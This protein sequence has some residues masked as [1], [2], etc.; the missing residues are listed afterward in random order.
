V[1]KL[2]SLTSDGI[3]SGLKLDVN[4]VGVS[5]VVTFKE[6]G[7]VGIGT[8]SPTSMF[9]VGSS[10][11]FQ[12]NSTGNIVSLNG[13][14]TSFPSTNASGALVNNGS[15]AF[16][17]SAIPSVG[18]W[19]AL[20]YPTWSSGTPFVKMTAAGTFSLDANT[21]ATG[22]GT[23][24]GTNTGDQTSV[25]GNAGTVTGLSVVSGKT[26]TVDNSLTIQGTDST[27]LSLAAALTVNTGTI[28]LIGNA[29]GSTLTLPSGSSSLSN[30]APLASPTFS[31][32][33]GGITAAMVGLGNVTNNSQALLT[34]P[35]NLQTGSI[36]TLVSSDAGGVVLM[37]CA[38]GGTLIVPASASV[39][40]PIGTQIDII[41]IGAGKITASGSSGVTINSQAGNKSVGAQYVGVTL[42]E[43][44]T[45]SWVL[46]GNLIT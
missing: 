40:F 18:T 30:Y 13:V 38:S 16:S 2:W 34:R 6:S 46:L 28:A 25:S 44:A 17:Y 3:A 26:L 24:S 5:N 35:L 29:A 43:T 9:S 32:T 20:N 1:S 42:L 12:V 11:Q 10:S 23:A 27:V 45:N 39:V 41:Q 15:G 8:T 4:G 14:A 21:Y 33:V 22:T 37:N 31:G 7:N 36:Y 19:G